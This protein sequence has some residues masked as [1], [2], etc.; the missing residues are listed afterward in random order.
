MYAAIGMHKAIFLGEPCLSTSHQVLQRLP[1]SLTIIRVEDVQKHLYFGA[2]A[3]WQ[4]ASQ[5]L[6]HAIPL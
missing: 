5:L 3:A 2:K 1:H 6:V 4:H